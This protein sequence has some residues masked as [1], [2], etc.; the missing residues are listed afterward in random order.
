M[1]L[2]TVFYTLGI[3]FMS[4]MIVIMFLCIVLLLYIK[5]K[6]TAI[7]D[8]VKSKIEFFNNVVNNPAEVAVDVGA[9]VARSAYRQVKKMVDKKQ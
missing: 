2:Q 3:I 1:D 9:A 5:H 4:L 7:H 6:I 8:M